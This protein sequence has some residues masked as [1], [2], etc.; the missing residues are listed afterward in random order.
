MKKILFTVWTTREGGGAEKILSNLTRELEKKYDIDVLEVGKFNNHKVN[1]GE[2]TR[3]L[4]PL[5]NKIDDRRIKYL[6]KRLFFEYVP[7]LYKRVRCRKKYDYEIAFNYLY[8]AYLINKNTKSIAWNHGSI[9]NLLDEKEKFNKIKYG[10]ALKNIDRIVAISNKTQQSIVDVY[11]E[12]ED[13]VVKI[14]NGYDFSDIIKN[15]KEEVEYEK[16]SLLFLGRLEEAKGIKR[17]LNIYLELV[18][19]DIKQKLY[20]LGEGEL[21]SWV[22]DFIKENS[23]EDRVI[24]LGY[25]SNPY[26]YIKSSSYILMTSK[27]EGFPTVF[28]EGLALGVGFVSTNV[29]G[30]EELSNLGKCGFVNDYDR[31]LINYLASEL[32]KDKKDRLIKKESCLGHV[33]NYTLEKQV[34]SLI[35]LLEEI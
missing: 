4:K 26:P 31:E 14:Y 9:E 17:L 15:S 5:L 25:K 23:L 1:L 19:K 11:P 7:N 18:K 34:S 3:L 29:G 22:E 27:G 2:K 30:V 13:K 12:Y 21:K 16:D 35:N 32:K 24:L 10:K 6:F 33:E 28:V 8:P 20:L